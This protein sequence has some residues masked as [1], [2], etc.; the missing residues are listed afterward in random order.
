[1]SFEE[2]DGEEYNSEEVARSNLEYQLDFARL[3][4]KFDISNP[5]FAH[6]ENQ[7][8]LIA[9]IGTPSERQ[10]L[11]NTFLRLRNCSHN[12]PEYFQ[13]TLWK[14]YDL[15]RIHLMDKSSIFL[16]GK[17]LEQNRNQYQKKA[18]RR[19]DRIKKLAK[20]NYKY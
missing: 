14:S 8:Y 6:L 19:S 2:S 17:V 20:V 13:Y 18:L 11:R 3:E 10:E 15:Q 5:D 16:Y 12:W 9:S 1:M 7:D 4:V